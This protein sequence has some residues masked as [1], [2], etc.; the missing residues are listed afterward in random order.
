MDDSV[1]F[2]LEGSAARYPP[3]PPLGKPLPPLAFQSLGV[4]TRRICRFS[5]SSMRV[6]ACGMDAGGG[7]RWPLQIAFVA[8]RF[9]GGGLR[10]G[11]HDQEV[12]G[13]SEDPRRASLLRQAPWLLRKCC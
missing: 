1:L 6:L 4:V 12:A 11:F 10:G 3:G 8:T 13:G 7:G 5:S 9:R 2:S